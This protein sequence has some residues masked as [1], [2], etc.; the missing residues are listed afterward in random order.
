MKK[1]WI[2]LKTTLERTTSSIAFIP[3]LFAVSGLLLSLL[4]VTLEYDPAVVDLKGNIDFLLVKNIED[5]RLVLGTAVSSIISLMVFSFSMVMIVLS[6]ASSTL[7]PRIL[8]GLISNK[9][10]QI[11][12]GFY[13]GTI[14]YSLIMI[15]NFQGDSEYTIPALGILIS[16]ILSVGCLS[17]F[18]YFIHS[19]SK[20]IQVDSILNTIFEETLNQLEV[21]DYKDPQSTDLVPAMDDWEEILTLKSGYLKNMKIRDLL[22]FA[23]ENDF[24]VGISKHVGVFIVKDYPYLKINCKE[25]LSKKTIANIRACFTFYTED[26]VKDHYFFGFKQISE[27]AAK[28]LSPGINDPGTAIKSL[29]LLSV[30]FI[31]RMEISEPMY[32]LDKNEVPR[33]FF[34]PVMLEELILHNLIPIREFGKSDVLVMVK[35]LEVLKNMVFADREKKKYTDTLS[36]TIKSIIQ[37]ADSA[38]KNSLDR[39]QVNLLIRIIDKTFSEKQVLKHL[40]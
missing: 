28:A 12:L 40:E 29:D 23:K 19:I 9:P 10:H 27:I 33:I 39:E 37:C 36:E 17:L 34:S 31:K 1:I 4:T 5:G 6:Q 21:S 15:V 26:Q 35:L 13:L 20:S 14:L 24:Q 3:T 38:L 8:P 30:L 11:I 22:N 25:K 7:S 32:A 16:M 2:T 18:I